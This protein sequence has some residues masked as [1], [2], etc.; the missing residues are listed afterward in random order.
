MRL[1]TVQLDLATAL[2]EFDVWITASLG[3]IRDTDRFR[4]VLEATASVFEIFGIATNN[5]DDISD[6]GPSRIADTYIDLSRSLP[7]EEANAK[8]QA[9]ASVM[10]LVTGKSDNNA[11]CQIPLH[12]RDKARWPSL[13]VPKRRN[14][15]IQLVPQPIPRELKADKYMGLV[16]SLIDHP[17]HQKRLLEEFLR[18]VLSDEK[19]VSQL[20]SIGRSYFMLKAFNRERDILTPLVVF[21]VRGSVA[22][23]GGH[24]PETLLRNRLSEWGLLEDVDYNLLDAVLQAQSATSVAN[25][26]AP[27]VRGKS[28]AY[29][30]LLPYRLPGWSPK[31]FI[32]C[33]FYAG[34]SGSVSHKN[35]DQ[36]STSR[37]SIK[38]QEPN[39]IF[40]EYLDGA[41]Y[42]SSLNGDLK[43]L[44]SMP[45]TASF[46]QVRSAAIR[47]RRNIQQIGFLT[48]I[49]VEHAVLRSSG[50]S[51]QAGCLLREEGYS[52]GEI[53]RALQYCLT[54]GFITRAE[55]GRLNL[56]TERR[57]VARR[58]LLLDVIASFG[59]S[60]GST[61]GSSRGVLMV[62]GYGPFFGMSL[63]DLGRKA[64]GLATELRSDWSDPAVLLG[65]I[66]WLCEQ[67]LAMSS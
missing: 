47:L 42:F 40:V 32:Q 38:A 52:Q 5:F 66:H 55:P 23:S 8:L 16:A 29:D 9:L 49:E 64:S 54:R 46:F 44:L 53:D 1:P 41:G 10:F 65:D 31:I 60:L 50:S 22:A 63:D 25:A 18:F 20:W 57:P 7:R 13:L 30:F 15:G 24:D 43:T 39:A 37:A 11:K 36:T 19:Y 6:C 3:E 61:P 14:G 33:Q 2:A 27:A 21:Q 59:V 45:D 26:E 56:S 51:D 17:D 67:G 62:P 35:V 48:P 34:D 12:L 4:E 28:R 58:Y